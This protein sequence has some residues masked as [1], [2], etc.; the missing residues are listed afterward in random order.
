MARPIRR[1]VAGQDAG[2]RAV[3]TV[4]GPATNIA[5]SEHPAGRTVE[6]PSNGVDF[7][8]A[9]FPPEDAG[10]IAALDGARAFAETGAAHRVVRGA[11]HPMMHRTDTVDCAIVL[12][13]EI[14]MPLDEQDV[15]LATGDVVI[16]RGTKHAWSNRYDRL[17]R[18]AFILIDAVD[19]YGRKRP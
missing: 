4:D 16:R 1:V 10:A 19:E 12:E 6:P 18:I 14:D 7:R 11:R 5:T 13:G 17:C 8:I 15:H 2:G 9:E 3:V